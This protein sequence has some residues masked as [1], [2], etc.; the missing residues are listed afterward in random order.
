MACIRNVCIIS[1]INTTSIL[2]AKS[3]KETYLVWLW[4]HILDN[5]YD[6]T[7]VWNMICVAIY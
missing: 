3:Y 5:I 6:I 4:K 1:S 7:L 2:V